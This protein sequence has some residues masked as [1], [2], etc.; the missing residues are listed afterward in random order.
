MKSIFQI[1]L[2]ILLLAA[3]SG[4]LALKD[5]T[6]FIQVNAPAGNFL[7]EEEESFYVFRGV[8]YAE[9]PVGDLR[10]RAPRA[11]SVS[12]DVIDATKFKSECIQPGTEGLIP[13]RNVSVGNEDC[14]YLNIYIPKNQTEINKNKFPVMF[15]IHGG[16]NIWGS[17]DFYDF[18]KLATT[19]QV[20]VITVNYRLGLFGWFS[21]EHLR[22]T[23]TGLDKSSNF[24][25]LDLIKG[26]EWV[27]ENISA[28]G[29]DKEN[30][31]IFGES[32]GGHNV[33]TLLASPL[34]KG[35]FHKAISQSGYVSSYT[36]KFA[37]EESEL[38]SKKIFEDDIKFLVNDNEVAD[39]LRSLSSEEIYQ[40]YKAKAE[41]HI[42]PITPITIKDGIVVPLSGIHKSLE[43]IDENLVVVAGTNKDEMNFWYVRS[44]YFYN[45]TGGV[46]LRLQRSEE[47]LKSWIKYR[48]D[49][50]RYDGAEEP[51]RRMANTNSN[52]YAY[53]FDWD[54]QNNSSFA[55]NY[56][57]FVG[58]AHGLEI[59]FLTGDFDLGP[60]T[61]YIKPFM[62]PDDSDEGR[63]ALSDLMMTYWANIAKYGNPNEFVKGPKWE[64]FTQEN[65]QLLILDNPTANLVEMRTIP[66]SKDD[67]LSQI[68]A[69]SALE[70]KERCLIGWIAARNFQED[71]RP[72]PPFNFCS[73]FTEEDLYK[74]RNLTEGRD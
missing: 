15:W 19:Q 31:T 68:E 39:Y 71:A 72:Q 44:N 30:V 26:L 32:A 55:G 38:S 34:S 41:E 17:G 10:W 22:N 45:S 23:A 56:Q 62:F 12:N 70:I 6:S 59:P 73:N 3:C 16:S 25:Q 42:Y 64:K 52:L 21:S 27:Q 47:N 5:S 8:P 4:G 63:L 2:A 57:L 40:K 36:Q 1:I 35:L 58:A 7:G 33:L 53:R 50:W 69:D 29:G 43:T 61:F 37:E 66:V 24:G 67:L 46:V 20:I 28:F 54:E 18:S 74:L 9:P 51:L 13:N 11:P 48:S 60:I 49:I 65:N 14:L